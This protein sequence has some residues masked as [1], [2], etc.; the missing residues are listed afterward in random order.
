MPKSSKSKRSIMM[1]SKL[2]FEYCLLQGNI[3]HIKKHKS[4]ACKACKASKDVWTVEETLLYPYVQLNNVSLK[5]VD[6][7]M[8]DM[9]NEDILDKL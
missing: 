3:Y 8:I 6:T 2:E 7:N 4:K 1:L 9:K 5:N